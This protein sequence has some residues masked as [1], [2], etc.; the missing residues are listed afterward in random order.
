MITVKVQAM[1]A[2]ELKHV[3]YNKRNR[4]ACKTVDKIV[5]VHCKLRLVDK[6]EDI[7]YADE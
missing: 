4:L 6:I 2:Y 3:T 5:K 7:C 1:M